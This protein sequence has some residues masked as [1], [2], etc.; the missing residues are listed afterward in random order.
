MCGRHYSRHPGHRDIGNRKHS[1]FKH[2]HRTSI[3]PQRR[4]ITKSNMIL[5]EPCLSGDVVSWRKGHRQ[6]KVGSGKT[7]GSMT[8]P[9]GVVLP[10]SA[11]VLSSDL[12]SWRRSLCSELIRTEKRSWMPSFVVEINCHFIKQLTCR[13]TAWVAIRVI[14]SGMPYS[15][16]VCEKSVI[17]RICFGEHNI[18]EILT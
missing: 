1:R 15:C 12:S 17:I 6:G 11:P 10:T 8:I 2:C 18:W 9:T 16:R 14:C 4:Q 3:S 5:A 13:T 7:R